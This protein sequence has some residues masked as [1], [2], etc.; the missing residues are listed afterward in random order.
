[1]NARI[2][3]TWCN[4]F[5]NFCGI[6]KSDRPKIWFKKFPHHIFTKG[7]Q[8]GAGLYKEGVVRS[9]CTIWV[10]AKW[11]RTRQT[12]IWHTLGHEFGHHLVAMTG[13]RMQSDEDEQRLCDLIG[14]VLM[15]IME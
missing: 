8:Q 7:E 6:F 1:M 3:Q 15:E 9:D 13:I 10:N 11:H 12:W 14:N 2:L 4:R 5:C